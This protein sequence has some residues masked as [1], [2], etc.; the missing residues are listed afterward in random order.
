[1]TDDD[2][3]EI[4]PTIPSIV[5]IGSLP[6]SVSPPHNYVNRRTIAL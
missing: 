2:E 3:R 6:A 5:L 1:M 4:A